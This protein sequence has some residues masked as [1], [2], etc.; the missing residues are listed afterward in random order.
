MKLNDCTSHVLTTGAIDT[1]ASEK[2]QPLVDNEALRSE[3]NGAEIFDGSEG[4][5]RL[6][7]TIHYKQATVTLGILSFPDYQSCHRQ[8]HICEY[9]LKNANK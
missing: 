2:R 6:K 9:W 7:K 5:N 4:S 1:P 3:A 8:P